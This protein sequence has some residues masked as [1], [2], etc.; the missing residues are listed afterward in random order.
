[1]IDSAPPT[2][3]YLEFTDLHIVHDNRYDEGLNTMWIYLDAGIRLH[4]R[5]GRLRLPLIPL[6]TH[7]DQNAAETRTP[8]PRSSAS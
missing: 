6:S 8:M 3:P 4:P 7:D 2:T 1:M 5:P